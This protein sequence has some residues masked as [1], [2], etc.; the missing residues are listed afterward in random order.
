MGIFTPK[1][2]D[3]ARARAAP[4]TVSHNTWDRTVGTQ[5]G[6]AYTATELQKRQRES[7][8]ANRRKRH[9]N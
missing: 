6:P 7:R 4:N 3:G 8:L 1:G 5:T 2:S 9:Q